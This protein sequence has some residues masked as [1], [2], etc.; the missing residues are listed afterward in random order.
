M[1][2]ILI[3]IGILCWVGT[4]EAQQ[5]SGIFQ[6]SDAEFEY[7]EELDWDSFLA[8]DIALN[9]QGFR[10]IN[11]ETTGVGKERKYWGIYIESAVRDTIIKTSSWPEMI[12]AKRSMAAAGFVLS[13]V[14][15][16]AL[17]A[18]DAHF[19]GVWYKDENQTPHKVWKLDSPQSLRD[20]TEDMSKQQFY[21]Q[22]VEVFLTPSGEANYLAVYHHSPLPIRNY[23]YITD[24]EQQFRDDFKERF[25]SKIRL[26]DFEQF[27]AKDGTYL[28]G[29]YQPGV[30]DYQFVQGLDRST[31]N[32]KWEQFEKEELRL[33]SWE[34]R[35]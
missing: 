19:V 20:K 15:A 11:L 27:E 32:G 25:E 33:V 4:V 23:V 12:K 26:F 3:V 5:I 7:I 31:F 29:V 1:K 35:D 10:L 30:Y 28:L 18:I 13:N 34:V 8:Q 16:Y 21:I 22:E 6:S 24:T 17:S 9:Q 14:Q 2:N